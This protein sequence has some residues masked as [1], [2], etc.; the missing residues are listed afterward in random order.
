MQG[1]YHSK[2]TA[3][4]DIFLFRTFHMFCQAIK[5]TYSYF[6]SDNKDDQRI[7]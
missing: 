5:H 4:K 6:P 7:N 2:T 3:G 1:E